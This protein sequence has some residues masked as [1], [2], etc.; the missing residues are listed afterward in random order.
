MLCAVLFAPVLT[1]QDAGGQT[2]QA[3]FESVSRIT[4]QTTLIGISLREVISRFGPPDAVYPMRGDAPWQ[5][6]VVFAYKDADFFIIKDRV[7]Q[8]R[9]QSANG[10]RNGDA[11]I[12]ISMMHGESA[13]DKGNR[14][15]VTLR[16]YAIPL[17]YHYYI[18][19]R[20]HVQAIY[21]CRSDF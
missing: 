16:G 8:I 3:A 14:V 21:L 18:D 20:G 15:I 5:D 17:E 11:K 13:A 7:W 9:V 4:D 1:A 19:P 10:I 6:D 12:T 2:T